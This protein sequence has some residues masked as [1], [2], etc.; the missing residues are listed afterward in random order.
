MVNP[1]TSS[2][3][4]PLKLFYTS[5]IANEADRFCNLD[6]S[7]IFFSRFLHSTICGHSFCRT[8]GLIVCDKKWWLTILWKYF[9]A[10][11]YLLSSHHRTDIG[12]SLRILM[13]NCSP[14]FISQNVCP[15]I[16]KSPFHK[17]FYWN[18]IYFS[19]QKIEETLSCLLWQMSKMETLEAK[20]YP[21]NF[22]VIEYK[23]CSKLDPP[24][25]QTRLDSN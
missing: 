24:W 23:F 4:D 9:I 14:A 8:P 13:L 6:F 21:F 2:R 10:C 3:I 11:C 7:N 17:I 19:D 5:W 12:H 20:V 25:I 22:W 18:S 15:A 1:S 16:S